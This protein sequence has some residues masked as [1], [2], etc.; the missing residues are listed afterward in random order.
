MKE[1]K[2][3]IIDFLAVTKLKE[4]T[5][6]MIICLHGPPGV[7]KTSFAYSLGKSLDRKVGRVSLGGESDV[8][9]IKGMRRTYIGSTPGNIV[10]EIQKCGI[11]NPV[12][13]LDEVDKLSGSSNRGDPVSVL[14]EIL[15]PEQNKGFTDNYFDFP[16][17]LS[18]VLFVCTA[19]DI[20]RIPGPLKDRMEMIELSSYTSKEKEMILE[21]HI[22]P[23]L[24]EEAGLQEHKESIVIDDDI[25]EF[26]ING[27][28]RE[29]GVRGLKKQ[30]AK[31]LENVAYNIVLNEE[32]ETG[33]V[34]SQEHR[35][36]I[37]NVTGY[38][39]SPKFQKENIY[40]GHSILYFQLFE[41]FL[42]QKSIRRVY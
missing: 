19:N 36:Q 1:V 38:L 2:S 3:K 37:D 18:K 7:G 9:S 5:E 34:S 28:C 23:N 32:N 27:Y 8:V 21:K 11:E 4:S 12:I 41:I 40:S 17:D 24:F 20:S 29:P 42:K 22:L 35:I 15:D 26:V 6:G 13:I 14:L 33:K 30:F 25:P 31:I 39:G 16:I 10:R